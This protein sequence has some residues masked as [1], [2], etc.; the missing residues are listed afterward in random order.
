M[1]QIGFFCRAP[2]LDLSTTGLCA[3]G[4]LSTVQR[5]TKTQPPTPVWP[6]LILPEA[7]GV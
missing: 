6:P 1:V 7:L 4:P 2:D 3:Q 5:H